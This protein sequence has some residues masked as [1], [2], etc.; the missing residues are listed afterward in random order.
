M[1]RPS[2]GPLAIALLTLRLVGLMFASN[3]SP[4]TTQEDMSEA[5][6][7][8]GKYERLFHYACVPTLLSPNSP[9]LTKD[10]GS[11]YACFGLFSEH[12]VDQILYVH[13][14]APITLQDR[15]WEGV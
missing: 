14:R 5:P 2:R 8:L 7:P 11:K 6:E 15:A 3:F 4:D 13:K 9:G 1:L 12:H 10:P